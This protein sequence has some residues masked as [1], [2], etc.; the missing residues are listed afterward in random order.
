MRKNLSPEPAAPAAPVNPDPTR[1]LVQEVPAPG[2]SAALGA[3]EFDDAR[4]IAAARKSRPGGYLRVPLE[5]VKAIGKIPILLSKAMIGSDLV[6]R[7][8]LIPAP[9]GVRIR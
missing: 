8:R 2:E 4:S 1:V 6:V 5:A 7:V 9:V 3:A